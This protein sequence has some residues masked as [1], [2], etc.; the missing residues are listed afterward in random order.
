MKCVLRICLAAATSAMLAT[1]AW[2]LPS[3]LTNNAWHR[4]SYQ[5]PQLQFVSGKIASVGKGSFTLTLEMQDAASQ[6]Q[7]FQDHPSSPETMTFTID[8]STTLEGKLKVGSGANVIY[9]QTSRGNMAV[10]VHVN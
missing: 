2:A 1:M 9:R 7:Q 10:S 8:K 3:R 6:G 4:E 5:D